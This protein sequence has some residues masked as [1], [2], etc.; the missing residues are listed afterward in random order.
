MPTLGRR[1]ARNL[2]LLALCVSAAGEVES[3][4]VRA[5][6]L[7]LIHGEPRKGW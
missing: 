4:P 3:T 6:F 2:C 5:V 1:R 7:L